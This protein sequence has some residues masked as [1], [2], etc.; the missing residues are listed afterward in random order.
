MKQ[1]VQNVLSASAGT[2]LG[3][4]LNAGF[5]VYQFERGL[6]AQQEEEARLRSEQLYEEWQ[7]LE[8]LARKTDRAIEEQ[9][10][11]EETARNIHEIYRH[12]RKVGDYILAGRA[13]RDAVAR[14]YGGRLDGWSSNFRAVGGPST[15]MNYQLF[16]AADF[17]KYRA[18][19]R[20]LEHLSLQ[21]TAETPLEELGTL[22][23]D[24]P[25]EEYIEHEPL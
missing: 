2:V 20:A 4:L 12:F 7:A 14:L 6:E 5:D 13:D 25:I 16:T 18:L 17:E 9:R 22:E 8:V 3:V 15:G 1:W 19:S 24:M 11:T 23:S 10:I 21:E